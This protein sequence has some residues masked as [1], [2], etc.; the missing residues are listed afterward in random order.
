MG[1]MRGQAPSYDRLF[2]VAARQAGLFTAQQAAEVGYSA[3]LLI[4]HVKA[5][6]VRRVLRGIYRLVHFPAS[7]QEE[8]VVAWLWSDRVGVVSHESALALHGLTDERPDHVH[9]TVPSAWQRRRAREPECVALHFEDVP[10]HHR[11][12]AGSVP[13]TTAARTIA[14]C[15]RLSLDQQQRA[16]DEALRRGLANESDLATIV[17]GIQTRREWL[18]LDAPPGPSQRTAIH[19]RP[20]RRRAPRYNPSCDGPV[21]TPRKP[22]TYRTPRQRAGA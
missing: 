6:N 1:A 20:H 5:G 21:E 22:L 15:W 9:V 11:T 19:E 2:E 17:R 16:C 14:Q 12:L 3:Q 4:H 8:L 13:V 18:R 7:S 10:S